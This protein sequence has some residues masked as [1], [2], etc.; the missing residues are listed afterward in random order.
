MSKL[1]MTDPKLEIEMIL[2]FE[3]TLLFAGSE[4]IPAVVM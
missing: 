4:I 1:T 2:L 3:A